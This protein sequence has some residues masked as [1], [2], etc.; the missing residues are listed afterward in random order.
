VVLLHGCCHNPTGLDPDAALWREIAQVLKERKILPL[1]D[2]A[3]QG[4]AAGIAEDGEG[5]E[6]SSRLVPRS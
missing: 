2:F 5:C 6:S 1:V 3:Y 4:L